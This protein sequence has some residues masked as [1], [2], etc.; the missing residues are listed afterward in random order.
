MKNNNVL[1][2]ILGGVAVGAALG[3]L[4]APAKGSETRKKIADKGNDLKDNF[5]DSLSKLTDKISKSVEGFKDEA[6]DLIAEAEQKIKEE[7]TN[8]ENLKDINESVL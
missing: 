2:G 4:F 8:L 7:K 5:K 6:Q 3:I 1:L